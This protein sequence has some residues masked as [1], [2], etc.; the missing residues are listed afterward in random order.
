MKYI[1]N[2]SEYIPEGICDKIMKGSDVK[3]FLTEYH[4]PEEW[5]HWKEAGY[6]DEMLS[7]YDLLNKDLN[8]DVCLPSE[9]FG[10]ILEIWFSRLDP[11]ELLPLHQDGYDFDPNFSRY[12]MFLQDYIPGHVFVYGDEIITGYKSGDV[13]QFDNPFIWYAA[14]NMGLQSRF[15][16]QICS[17]KL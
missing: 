17:K 16:M 4:N 10:D 13:Y 15:T 11:G 3:S 5:K 14:C 9:V 1:G 6:S 7:Y 2:F 8:I 12:S